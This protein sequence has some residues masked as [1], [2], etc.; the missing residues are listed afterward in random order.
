VYAARSQAPRRAPD[1][2]PCRVKAVLG[3]VKPSSGRPTQPPGDWLR[4]VLRRRPIQEHPVQ[5]E[6]ADRVDERA[7]LDGFA[8]VAVGAEVVA[9]DHVGVLARGGSLSAKVDVQW[10]PVREAGRLTRDDRCCFSTCARGPSFSAAGWRAKSRGM[11]EQCKELA[12]TPA[13]VAD[14][15][16]ASLELRTYDRPLNVVDGAIGSRMARCHEDRELVSPFR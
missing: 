15:G 11:C 16:K 13:L 10:L 4:R 5:S 14:E 1:C 3:T 8:H 7:E 2:H 12:M 9:R 6:A